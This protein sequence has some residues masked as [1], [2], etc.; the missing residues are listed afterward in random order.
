LDEIK[1]LLD[2]QLEDTATDV[3]QITEPLREEVPKQIQERYTNRF[4]VSTDLLRPRK[5]NSISLP[6]EDIPTWE[7]EHIDLYKR[8][9][10]QSWLIRSPVTS[11]PLNKE[12]S[13]QRQREQD[14]IEQ[15]KRVQ[16]SRLSSARLEKKKKAARIKDVAPKLLKIIQYMKKKPQS[17]S[18]D[19]VVNETPR[20]ER[21]LTPVEKKRHYLCTNARTALILDFV[22]PWN[23][24]SLIDNG[25][26]KYSNSLQARK[27]QF[28]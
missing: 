7:Y 24:N 22:Y 18:D 25:T 12:R 2:E 8:E 9:E 4:R 5:K 19:K 15:L 10:G 26:K 3:A 1:K 16:R 11:T 28:G 13:K 23:D 6:V 17:V 14:K 27:I 21:R 20:I